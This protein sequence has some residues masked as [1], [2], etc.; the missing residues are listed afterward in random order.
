MAP[1]SVPSQNALGGTDAAAGVASCGQCAGKRRVLPALVRLPPGL[2][3]LERGDTDAV[4]ATQIHSTR[5]SQWI[6]TV[7]K[8]A[9]V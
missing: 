7:P 8:W 5:D 2:A 6:A 3:S 4:Y 9:S 1:L